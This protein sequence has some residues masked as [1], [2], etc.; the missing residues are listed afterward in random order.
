MYHL[1][2]QIPGLTF[3]ALATTMR[4]IAALAVSSLVFPTWAFAGSNEATVPGGPLARAAVRE[5]LRAAQ[6]GPSPN[7]GNPYVK[8]AALMIAAGA[9]VAIMGSTM[10]Q[11]KTQTTDY[12]LCAAAQGGPTGPSTR[13][14]GCDSFRT[15][16]KGFLWAGGAAI[17]AGAS[18][19]TFGAMRNLTVQ[20]LPRGV[21]VG[22]TSRF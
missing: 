22:R 10:P 14:S 3:L 6:A 18:L 11:L 7:G 2:A 9:A 17:A 5:A 20:A 1:P 13:N 21:F 19:L 4:L 15:A 8:P 16:N 12:D